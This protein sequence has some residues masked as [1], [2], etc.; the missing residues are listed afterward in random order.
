[1]LRGEECTK[2]R[3]RRGERG[4]APGVVLLLGIG[5]ASVGRAQEISLPDAVRQTLSANLD[6]AAQRRQL[7]AAREE[8]GL[9]RSALLPQVGI[10]GGA[11]ILDVDRSDSA[12]GNIEARTLL[13]E[14]GLSQVL[15]DEESWAGFTIQK[16][17][18][19]SR[20]R[21]FEA[22]SLGVKIGRASCRERV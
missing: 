4:V 20:A 10:G 12:Q 1:M 14:A 19:E 6:L 18:Y 8:I 17:V 21:D 13:V 22:F 11:Q 3:L 15:Y 16:H 5:L 2:M 9:A 7:A